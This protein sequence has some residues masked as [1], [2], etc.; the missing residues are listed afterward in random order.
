MIYAKYLA[1]SLA[2]SKCSIMGDIA[3]CVVMPGEGEASA[4]RVRTEPVPTNV[5]VLS[6]PWEGSPWAQDCLGIMGPGQALRVAC[7]PL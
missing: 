2:Y 7:A 1:Q 3:D 4:W 5:R 6:A